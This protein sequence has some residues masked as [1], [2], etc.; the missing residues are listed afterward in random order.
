MW[1]C[2]KLHLNH[3]IML[4]RLWYGSI[5]VFV[6][7]YCVQVDITIIISKRFLNHV[8]ITYTAGYIPYNYVCDE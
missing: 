1:K 3:S 5:F 6:T 7:V 2:V 8:I 4:T